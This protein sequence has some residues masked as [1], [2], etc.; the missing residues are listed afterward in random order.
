[1]SDLKITWELPDFSSEEWRKAINKT[2]AEKITDAFDKEN[3]KED[4]D[5]T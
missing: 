3:P 4:R 1:M 2:A 5:E